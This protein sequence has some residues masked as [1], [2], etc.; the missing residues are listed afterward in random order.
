MDR[1]QALKNLG[2]GAGFLVATPTILGMLQSCVSEPEFNPVFLSKGEGH[3]LRRM[4]D[5]IIPNDD[6]VP[7]ANKVGVHAFIDLFW[8]DGIKE[9]D[10][11]HLRKAWKVFSDKFTEC[12]IKSLKKESQK[13][14][15]NF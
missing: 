1:R 3:A 5:L 10:Q 6:V 11:Q 15:I 13:N 7:G 9:K 14:L 12:L 8:K 4:V 2:Y